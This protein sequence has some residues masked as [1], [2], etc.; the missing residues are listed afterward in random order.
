MSRRDRN[1]EK[2]IA[3]QGGSAHGGGHQNT[4]QLAT[5]VP[6]LKYSTSE[7]VFGNRSII[8][9]G[10]SG[11]MD[12]FGS[13]VVIECSPVSAKNQPRLWFLPSKTHFWAG[14]EDE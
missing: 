1:N 8:R 4:D 10:H 5:A 13:H 12:M 6:H 14:N 3:G 7:R 9:T 11:S 2:F